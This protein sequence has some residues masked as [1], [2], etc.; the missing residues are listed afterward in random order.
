M[1]IG[2]FSYR[3]PEL[4]WSSLEESGYVRVRGKLKIAVIAEVRKAN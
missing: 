4:D 1:C 3:D 2:Q